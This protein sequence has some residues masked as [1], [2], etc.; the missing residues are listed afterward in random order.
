M[1]QFTR[2]EYLALVESMGEQARSLV[3]ALRPLVAQASIIRTATVLDDRGGAGE[4]DGG[5][6]GE[7]DQ[8]TAG[9]AGQVSRLVAACET[10]S[11]E[12]SCLCNPYVE[13]STETPPDRSWGG[14][15]VPG[16]SVPEPGVGFPTM[17]GPSMGMAREPR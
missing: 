6:G 8:E 2:T 1:A 3:L 10:L 16:E 7:V 13:P 5:A 11:L 9:R 14:E 12:A 4:G 15:D 17:W